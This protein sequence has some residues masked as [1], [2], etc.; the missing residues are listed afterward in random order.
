VK[1]LQ[2]D[3]GMQIITLL[4]IAFATVQWGGRDLRFGVALVLATWIAFLAGRRRQKPAADP[5][6]Q[7]L[8][9]LYAE[10]LLLRRFQL[11]PVEWLSLKDAQ[12]WMG[13]TKHEAERAL[14]ALAAQGKIAIDGLEVEP[15]SANRW[16]LTTTARRD[17]IERPPL[18]VP[19]DALEERRRVEEAESHV[20]AL[21][22]APRVS[23]S[24]RVT[25]RDA[26]LEFLGPGNT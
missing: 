3:T 10:H 21:L 22:R 15:L 20:R 25:D 23:E 8:D 1:R 18:D 4:A 24:D 6:Q 7:R 12:E 13:V 11:F 26:A 9:H 16:S 5:S 19:V 14:R 17:A 2:H